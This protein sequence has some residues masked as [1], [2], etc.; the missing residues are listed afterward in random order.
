[1]PEP[2]MKELP[3]GGHQR[4]GTQVEVEHDE[5]TPEIFSKANEGDE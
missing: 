1:M 3:G 2:F 4:E 5:D